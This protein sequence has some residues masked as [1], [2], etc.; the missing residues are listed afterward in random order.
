VTRVPA[1]VAVLAYV[2]GVFDGEGSVSITCAQQRYHTLRVE[3]VNTNPML[4][5]WLVEKMGGKITP[6]RQNQGLGTKPV[7][8]W[9][10]RNLNAEVFLREVLPYLIVK[11]EQAELALAF[12]AIRTARVRKG[13]WPT[14]TEEAIVERES[15]RHQLRAVNGR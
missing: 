11:R 15:I 10:L 7:F 9:I 12:R 1:P 2:A 3:I 14:V 13:R 4:M 5:Q 6:L 8:A